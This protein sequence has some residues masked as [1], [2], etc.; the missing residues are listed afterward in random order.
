MH[1][2]KQQSSSVAVTAYAVVATSG[3]L[4]SGG[5]TFPNN[6][7]EIVLIS[8]LTDA[9]QSNDRKKHALLERKTGRAG[10]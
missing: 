5:M 8:C 4:N 1:A 7:V 10:I 2:L 3:R 9:K 6:M